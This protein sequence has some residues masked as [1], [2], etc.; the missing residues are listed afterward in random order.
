MATWLS[1][2]RVGVSQHV[3]PRCAPLDHEDEVIGE[4]ITAENEIKLQACLFRA[5]FTDLGSH[6]HTCVENS[7]P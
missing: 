5:W 6:C 4:L 7:P 3:L 1:D 2:Y